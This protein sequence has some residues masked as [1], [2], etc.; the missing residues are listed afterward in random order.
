MPKR[1]TN[2]D[3]EFIH[4]ILLTHKNDAENAVRTTEGTNL[5]ELKR[6]INELDTISNIIDKLAP[7]PIEEATSV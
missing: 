6:Q 5:L 1:L 7:I 4:N 3:K 2:S